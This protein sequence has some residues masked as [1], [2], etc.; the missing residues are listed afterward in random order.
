[1]DLGS[2]IVGNGELVLRFSMRSV[3]LKCDF[4]LG[5]EKKNIHLHYDP[6]RKGGKKI[7]LN[8]RSHFYFLFG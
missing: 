3:G 8:L 2:G 5:F 4:E 1:M 6:M 7:K